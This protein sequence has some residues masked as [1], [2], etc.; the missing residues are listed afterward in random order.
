MAL[1]AAVCTPWFC[2]T[3]VRCCGPNS[4][5]MRRTR[6]NKDS[7]ARH[8]TNLV[9]PVR[10]LF[11]AIYQWHT[12]TGRAGNRVIWAAVVVTILLSLNILVLIQLLFAF[13]MTSPPLHSFPELARL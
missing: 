7:M 12:K 8:G 1:T 3:Q 5:T 13:G 2:S 6:S 11:F 10:Y 9:K 4:P